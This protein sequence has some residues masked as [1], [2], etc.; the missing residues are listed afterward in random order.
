[1]TRNTEN[2]T[3]MFV[4]YLTKFCR[5]KTKTCYIFYE[6]MFKCFGDL[7]KAIVINRSCFYDEILVKVMMN[8]SFKIFDSLNVNW[9]PLE[10]M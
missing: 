6:S 4:E 9:L 1:M 10:M 7:R 3:N 2:A 5:Y 8:A